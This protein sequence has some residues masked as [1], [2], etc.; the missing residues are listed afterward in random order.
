MQI[1]SGRL[2]PLA[3]P[4]ED[5]G[6]RP[7][8]VIQLQDD[9]GNIGQGEAA[10]FPGVTPD[11]PEQV[12]ATLEQVPWEKLPAINLEQPWEPQVRLLLTPIDLLCP[13][14]IFAAETAILDLLG[15]RTDRSLAA[16]LSGDRET[17]RIPLA[18]SYNRPLRHTPE[19]VAAV[20]R[21]L[22][23]KQTT[24]VLKLGS[25]HFVRELAVIKAIKRRFSE[26]IRLRLDVVE[27]WEGRV[28]RE[29]IT[30]LSQFNPELVTQPVA[31]LEMSSFRATVPIAVKDDVHDQRVLSMLLDVE[32]PGRED[33]L[34]PGPVQGNSLRSPRK[35]GKPYPEIHAVVLRPG[36][37][38]GLLRT[39]RIAAE[40][41]QL[42]YKVII[43]HI[44]DGVIARAAYAELA[45]SLDQPAL[46]CAID[47]TDLEVYELP[48]APPQ[49]TPNDFT[50]A[51][52][53]G[54]GLSML[55]T[56]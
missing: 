7:F 26:R 9:A 44:G 30:M 41:Q 4:L 54:L 5:V 49:F 39:R 50:S 27:P 13:S 8:F 15:Q 38:G 36:V 48:E 47:P 12:R 23:R 40:A 34:F 11:D 42:G 32:F 31:T 20:S 52:L 2:I 43:H 1:V 3:L 19:V 18:Y 24:V 16:I 46:G 22:E 29:R 51:G 17:A 10:P 53:P 56:D 33:L 28:A 45:S 6:E 25:P 37:L 55:K 35:P 21:A 14:A